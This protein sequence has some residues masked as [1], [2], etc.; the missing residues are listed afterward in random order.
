MAI[1][2][3]FVVWNSSRIGRGIR[4]PAPLPSEAPHGDTELHLRAAAAPAT[5]GLNRVQ[6]TVEGST[7][8]P[9]AALLA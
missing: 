5:V 8:I 9:P 4:I 6:A 2:S 7:P 1:S 3:A